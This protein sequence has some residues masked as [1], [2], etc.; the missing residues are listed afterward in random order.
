MEW[1]IWI[2]ENCMRGVE[3]GA[4]REILIKE[5]FSEKETEEYLCSVVSHPYV[6]AGRHIVQELESGRDLKLALQEYV[7]LACSHG[8]LSGDDFVGTSIPEEYL[9]LFAVPAFGHLATI[10]KDGAPQL[11]P[12]WVDYREPFLLVNSVVGRVKDRNVRRDPRICLEI[13][14]PRNPYRYLA[15]K[16]RV[17]EICLEGADAHIDLLAKK[18]YGVSTYPFHRS[19]EIRCV[20]KIEV[21]AVSWNVSSL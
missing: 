3:R 12:V 8:E 10:G 9:D 19:N 17:A 2:A 5:G 1:T 4:L 18:Y 15:I 7:R 13:V 6:L 14:D 16:G 20:Y 21:L 11:T